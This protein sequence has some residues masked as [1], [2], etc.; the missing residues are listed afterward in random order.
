MSRGCSHRRKR[1]VASNHLMGRNFAKKKLWGD[2]ADWRAAGT[3]ILGNLARSMELELKMKGS[4]SSSE[5]L[6]I[7]QIYRTSSWS[8]TEGTL[9]SYVSCKNFV[10]T[11]KC[12]TNNSNK[13]IA[14]FSSRAVRFH[15]EIRPRICHDFPKLS[16]LWIA[17]VACINTP[18]LRRSPR[19]GTK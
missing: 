6:Q 8:W 2:W 9:V 4:F 13:T 17:Q 7:L 5:N 12:Q 16:S 10:H 11:V 18:I 15:H 19:P 1:R 14:W 3:S